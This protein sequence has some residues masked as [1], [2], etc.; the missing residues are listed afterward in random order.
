MIADVSKTMVYRIAKWVNKTKGGIIPEASITKAPS[1]ELKPNQTDQDSLPSYDL[2][3]QI[4]YK[5]I[6]LH[7]TAEE[8][9]QEGFDKEVVTRVL[10]LVKK[11]EFKR[12]QAAPGIKITDRAFG[13]GWRMPIASNYTT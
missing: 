11:A 7:T 13:T 2:L 3:D 1:A 12:K 6:E 5:H 4:L 10:G 8:L 9:I